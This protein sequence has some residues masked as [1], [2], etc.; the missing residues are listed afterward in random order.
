MV[1]Q[2][3]ERRVKAFNYAKRFILSDK[4]LILWNKKTIMF[5]DVQRERI[6]SEKKVQVKKILLEIANLRDCLGVK[7]QEK[8]MQ[9][10]Q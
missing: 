5:G 1:S 8:K 4:K 2:Q 10:L 9:K 6:Q 7:K 3:I